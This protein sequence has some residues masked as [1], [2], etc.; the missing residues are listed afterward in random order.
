MVPQLQFTDMRQ[1]RLC[2]ICLSEAPFLRGRWHL[3]LLSA[4]D[5]H[6][7]KLIDRCPNCNTLTTPNSV[8][9]AQ[10][11]C[12]FLLSRVEMQGAGEAELAMS[13]AIAQSLAPI[14]A[15]AIELN[16][17]G[18]GTATL[19]EACKRIWFFGYV[20]RREYVANPGGHKR[21]PTL[22]EASV[23]NERAYEICANWPQA[24]DLRWQSEIQPLI[25]ASQPKRAAVAVGSINRYV[26]GQLQDD[27]FRTV[28]SIY[29]LWAFPPMPQ[30]H[31]RKRRLASPQL[32]LI[33]NEKRVK[34]DK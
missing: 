15:Q 23:I 16:Q 22:G 13:K 26:R 9:P 3:T 10:C 18:F 29:Q 6:A 19:E 7:T 17:F 5:L 12:G 20:L 30:S 28:A 11:G 4:C 34:R 2:S 24:F 25:D 1:V 33:E 14:Q 27:A 31:P 21:R 8:S 32:A